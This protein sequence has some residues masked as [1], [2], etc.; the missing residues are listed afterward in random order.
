M[1][2]IHAHVS[3]IWVF[4]FV[5]AAGPLL[6]SVS[7][8]AAITQ[9]SNTSG[10]VQRNVNGFG[11]VQNNNVSALAS[12]GGPLYAGT[13]NTGGAQVWCS[14]N[15]S[16]WVQLAPG[17]SSSY[18]SV[19][20]AEAFG[21][22]LY[23]GLGKDV[24]GGGE[25]W[26]TD[27]VSWSRAAAGGLGDANNTGFNALAIF[28]GSLF[29]ATTNMTSGVE[30]W[31]R[32]AG[33]VDSWQQKN[34]DGFGKGAT[35]QDV[36]MDVYD[37]HLYVGVGRSAS[38]AAELWR[39]DES[40]AWTDV[41]TDGLGNPNN[42]NVSAMAEFG[43]YFYV[44]LRNMTEGGEVWRSEN[45]LDWT[46]VITGGLG[47]AANT[48]P[49][50]LIAFDD[51]LYLVFSNLADGAQVWRTSDGVHWS[52]IAEGGWGDAYNV[53]SDYFDKAAAIFNNS[54]Y[55]GTLNNA[56]GGEIWQLQHQVY[57]PVVKGNYSP[58]ADV[59]FYN[60]IILTMEDNLPQA[61]AIAIKGDRIQAVGSNTDILS[62]QRSGTQVIDLHGLTLLPGFI[63]GHTHVL[64]V[65]EGKT[66]DEVQQV[67]LD[68]GLTSVTE[69]TA[70]QEYIDRLLSAEAAGLM[71]LRVNIF[72]NYNDSFL[73]E[74]GHSI[75]QGVWFPQH[76]PILDHDRKVRIPGIKVFADGAMLPGRGC[77]ALSEPY[78]EAFQA[79]PIFLNS[80]LRPNGDLYLDQAAMN[81]VV[82]QA[83]A[84]GYRVAFHTMGDRGI[85]VVLN[86][87]EYALNGASNTLYR[88]QIQHNSQLRPDQLPR[89]V[90]LSILAS[91]RGAWQACDEDED[92]YL[93]AYG[94][95]RYQ[96]A[97]NRYALPGLGVHAYAEGDFG[98]GT[99]PSDRTTVRP[100]DPIMLLW[101]LMTRQR[102]Q[103]DGMVCQPADW[104][105]R[106]AIT[107]QQALR[108]LTIEP[109]YAV[110]QE[111]YIGSLKPGKYA[112]LVILSGNPL[113]TASDDLLDLRVWMTMVGGKMEH[114]AS[115]QAGLCPDNR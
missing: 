59:I 27:G 4:A 37:G 8:R 90:G 41:F 49:Y 53:Y 68:L 99:D 110:S 87:I 43:G 32:L 7:T 101:G 17:W 35:A 80:C 50:G 109:A 33:D 89:Y 83:Q 62:L 15:G 102:L 77:P 11:A 86:A 38:Q 26:R 36:T 54:L 56:G 107:V 82:T 113:S 20:D 48:R 34:S 115:G 6:A 16:D 84:A 22:A 79:D 95:D 13:W 96:D 24:V 106:H 1:K 75:Y 5:L 92:W 64:W 97:A 85:D 94:P 51:Q 60:G 3:G 9:A 91:V 66:L 98:W 10:W 69:M 40:L 19:F 58:P 74:Q 72:P 42:S 52:R 67:A 18:T 108:M 28:S 78:S 55:I 112:D 30:I 44:G 111:D 31:R 14:T 57:L 12:F 71:R 21:G 2:P 81:Q 70:N 88:H 93:Y 63:D 65:P 45:G 39:A 73:D 114:C 104:V 25:I 61:Q 47:T 76:A 29:A 105:S 46:P 100:L 103:A 23:F